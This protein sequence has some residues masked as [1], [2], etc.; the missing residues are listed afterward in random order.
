VL[1]FIIEKIGCLA[2]Q[3]DGGGGT[4]GSDYV[5]PTLTLP[6]CLQYTNGL[7]QT[8]TQLQH[9]DYTLRLANQYCSLKTTVDTHTT[10]ISTL[11]N[12]VTTLENAPGVSLPQVTPNCILPATPTA[13]N[14]VLDEL[15]AQFCQLREVLGTVQ[16]LTA[17]AAQQCAGLGLQRAYSQAGTLNGLPGW[18]QT[19]TT[20][21]D[22]FTNLWLTVCDMRAGLAS[23]ATSV[24][25][26]DCSAFA[27]NFAASP[28]NDRTVITLFFNGR[29]SF[30]AGFTNCT[31]QGSKVTIADDLGNTFIG[32]VDLVAAVADVDGIPFTVTS[33]NLNTSRPYTVTVEACLTKDGQTC[34]K[35]RTE[36]VSVPCSTVS[37]VSATLS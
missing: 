6:T 18:R 29:T 27:L 26:V 34:S 14:V 28:N 19:I 5:E 20:L 23:V 25:T 1:G 7:G 9:G 12:R 13:M 35:T 31:A 8:V 36:T 16:S 10:Q 2:E 32:Y 30:P 4:G 24:G 11:S 22:S 15:E 37:I 21:A 3:V 17:A 33:G